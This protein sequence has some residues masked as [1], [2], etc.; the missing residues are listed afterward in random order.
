MKP[1]GI[2]RLTN[3]PTYEKSHA[4]WLGGL[5][6]EVKLNAKSFCGNSDIIQMQTVKT[7]LDV[8][9]STI[10]LTIYYP[11]TVR[12]WCEMPQTTSFNSN[13]VN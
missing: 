12:V 3:K 10:T 2:A 7:F 1:K 9:F 5:G 6:P 11:R 4:M 8:L 13:S